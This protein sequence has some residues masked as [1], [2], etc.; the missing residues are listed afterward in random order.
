M[1]NGTWMIAFELTRKILMSL[2]FYMDAKSEIGLIWVEL[3][4]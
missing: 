2:Y 4:G 1:S 3:L